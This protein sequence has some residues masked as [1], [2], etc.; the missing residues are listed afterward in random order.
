MI[1]DYFIHKLTEENPPEANETKCINSFGKICECKICIEICPEHAVK[2]KG[3]SVVYDS[4]LCTKCGMCKSKCPTQA[5]MLKVT[6]ENDLINCADEKKNLVFSCSLEGGEGN[7]NISCLNALHPELIAS[8]IM[9]YKDKKFHFNLSKCE[10]CKLGCDDSLFREALNKAVSFTESL[11]IDVS[12]EIHMEEKELSNLIVEEISRR[13]LFKL[14]R[15]ESGNF[16]LKTINTIIDNEDS[17]LSYR[18]ILLINMKNLRSE[19]K[20]N[21]SNIFWEYWDVNTDCDGCGKCESVCP[22]KAWKIENTETNV[23]LYHNPGNCYKCG[24]CEK[25]CTKK[26]IIVGDVGNVDLWEFRLKREINLSICKTCNRK[27]ISYDQD[28][29]QCDVCRKKELL[30]RKISTS[31]N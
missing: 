3:K 20:R 25:I 9:M 11:G 30:R 19:H 5:I 7:L 14:V 1:L 18:K 10:K 12:Y 21:C 17:Q 22:G 27:F 16:A 13:D 4:K 15:K 8:L 6:G 2:L 31:L 23:N 28:K 26:A 24:L 29:D